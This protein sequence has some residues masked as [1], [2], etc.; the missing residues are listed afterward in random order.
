MTS[1][2]FFN[3]FLEIYINTLQ[4]VKLFAKQRVDDLRRDKLKFLHE[5][6]AWVNPR[7]C[8]LQVVRGHGKK[9]K[10]KKEIKKVRVYVRA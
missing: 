4:T 8:S 10:K 6:V 3:Y 2:S 5:H 9:E 1:L 7:V